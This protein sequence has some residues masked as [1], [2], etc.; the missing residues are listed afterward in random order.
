MKCV[1]LRGFYLAGVPHKKGD[2]VEV[3]DQL[4]RHLE[5]TGKIERAPEPAPAP[6]VGAPAPASAKAAPKGK[7]AMTTQSVPALV[8][9]AAPTKETSH[10]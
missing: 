6:A 1:A 3:P 7:A 9:G 5:L 10:D 2:K 8:P 4:V